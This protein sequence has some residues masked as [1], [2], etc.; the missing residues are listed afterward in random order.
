MRF[1]KIEKAKTDELVIEKLT[2][3]IENITNG[4]EILLIVDLNARTIENTAV[5]GKYGEDHLSDSGERQLL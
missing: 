4:K 2:E 5:V 3:P 1:Q